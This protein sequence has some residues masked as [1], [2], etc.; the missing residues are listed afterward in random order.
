V[1]FYN[2]LSPFR[3]NVSY[4]RSCEIRM[5]VRIGPRLIILPGVSRAW[6]KSLAIASTCSGTCF[7]SKPRVLV[8][9][10]DERLRKIE[11]NCNLAWCCV[12][13]KSLK[14]RQN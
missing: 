8:E 6:Q 9:I 12:H 7:L 4:S 1:K 14:R 5:D 13:D 10:G 2:I 3:E 11:D